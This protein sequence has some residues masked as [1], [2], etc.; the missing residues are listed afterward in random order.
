MVVIQIQLVTEAKVEYDVKTNLQPSEYMI[1][2]QIQLVSEVGMSLFWRNFCPWLHRYLSFQQC[3][4][5]SVKKIRKFRQNDNN[6]L[7]VVWKMKL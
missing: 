1:V 6:S 2:I 3:L 7:P 4:V 5:Q